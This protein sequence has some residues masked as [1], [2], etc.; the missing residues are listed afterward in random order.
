MSSKTTTDKGAV[1]LRAMNG[2]AQE[3]P[4]A[5]EPVPAAPKAEPPP[6]R[7]GRK[8]IGGYFDRAEVEKIAILRARLNLDNSQLISLAIDDLFKKNEARRALGD[9]GCTVAEPQ[10]STGAPVHRCSPR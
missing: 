7:K 6:T 10:V 4:A 9:A 5:V 1:F 2:G 8:H 3:Q